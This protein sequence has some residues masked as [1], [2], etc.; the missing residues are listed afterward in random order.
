MIFLRFFNTCKVLNVNYQNELVML[1]RYV[2]MSNLNNNKL[3][4]SDRRT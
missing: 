1:L 4:R 3:N 2:N